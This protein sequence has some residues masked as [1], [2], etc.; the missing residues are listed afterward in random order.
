MKDLQIKFQKTYFIQKLSQ[1]INL[2]QKKFISFVRW[3]LI[4]AKFLLYNS[5]EINEII[6]IKNKL[7]KN[8]LILINFHLIIIKISN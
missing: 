4:L 3:S 6:K 7:A 8:L 2:S 5:L 1:I